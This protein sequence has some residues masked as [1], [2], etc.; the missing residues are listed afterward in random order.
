MV[1]DIVD[2]EGN[3]NTL[4]VSIALILSIALIPS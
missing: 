2:Y 3:S 4:D 1:V